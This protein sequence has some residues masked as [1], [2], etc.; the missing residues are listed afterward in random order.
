MNTENHISPIHRP[1]CWVHHASP[2]QASR[3]HMSIWHVGFAT[4]IFL[5]LSKW[6]TKRE[7][8]KSHGALRLHLFMQILFNWSAFNNFMSFSGLECDIAADEFARLIIEHTAHPQH[9]L[10]HLGVDHDRHRPFAAKQQQCCQGLRSYAHRSL[11]YA[12]QLWEELSVLICF[13]IILV[14]YCVAL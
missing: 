10:S 12:L 4:S 8:L 13:V 5:S 9:G 6:G 1:Q 3:L 14:A 2:V 7:W 11:H